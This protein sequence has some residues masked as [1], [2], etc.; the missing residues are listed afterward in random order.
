MLLSIIFGVVGI[1]FLVMGILFIKY[2]KIELLHDYHRDKIKEEDKNVVCN[3]CG[4]GM[5]IIAVGM[6][7]TAVIFGITE[8]ML[9]LIPFGVCFLV[10]LSIMLYTTLKYNKYGSF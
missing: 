6:I 2:K 9:S 10:G 8:D 7:A 1:I 4:T 5:I 3:F